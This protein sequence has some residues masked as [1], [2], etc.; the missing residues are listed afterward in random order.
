MFGI[1]VT[2]VML[3]KVHLLVGDDVVA[4]GC[5]LKG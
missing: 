5:C 3:S 1:M 4:D 2:S